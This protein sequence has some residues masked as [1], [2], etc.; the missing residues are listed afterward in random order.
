VTALALR[1]GEH[2]E[3]RNRVGIDF[4]PGAGGRDGRLD[5]PVHVECG[6]SNLVQLGI[7]RILEEQAIDEL[8]GRGRT[9]DVEVVPSE[10]DGI[11]HERTP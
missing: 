6:S 1:E 7:C 9:L 5:S 2:G 10:C 4:E 11:A 8:E 3:E